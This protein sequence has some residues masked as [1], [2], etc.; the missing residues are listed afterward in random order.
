[1]ACE[2]GEVLEVRDK[3]GNCKW[4]ASHSVGPVG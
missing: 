3:V 1:M 4:L 2:A